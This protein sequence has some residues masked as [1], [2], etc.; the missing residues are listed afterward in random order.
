MRYNPLNPPR[1]VR[2]RLASALAPSSNFSLRVQTPCVTHLTFCVSQN[3]IQMSKNHG[4]R[5]RTPFPFG[6][7]IYLQVTRRSAR[8]QRQW[9]IQLHSASS[10]S[11]PP[12]LNEVPPQSPAASSPQPWVNRPKIPST[13]KRLCLCGK[14]VKAD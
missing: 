10:F 5:A 13:L 1:F 14:G 6:R 4:G 7:E 12:S 11:R 3:P 2:I 9:H 8:P